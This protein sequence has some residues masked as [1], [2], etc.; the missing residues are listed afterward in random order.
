[1]IDCSSIQKSYGL[2]DLGQVGYKW[3]NVDIHVFANSENPV[4]IDGETGTGK[5][6]VAAAVHYNSPRRDKIFVIQNCSAFSDILLSSDLFGHEKDSFKGAILDKKG[7]FEIADGGTLFLDEIGDMNIDVQTKL[8]RVMEDGTFYTVGGTEQK[9]VNVRIITVTNKELEKQVEKGLFRK[10]L[11]YRIN[12]MHIT[13]PPLRERK[14]DILLL[15][16]YFIEI[17]AE[18]LNSEKK[19]LSQEVIEQLLEYK[20]PGNVRELKNFIDRLIII[21]GRERVIKLTH[22]PRDARGASLLV[23]D[24]T[25]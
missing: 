16:N 23:S 6:F 19:E 14:D 25:E 20:W 7:M 24:S 18:I 22:L 2:N 21:S 5:E 15:A 8:L 13:V 1:M 11:F 9:K 10:D 4:L 3:W 12:T 17:Y